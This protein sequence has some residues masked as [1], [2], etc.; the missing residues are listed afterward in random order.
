MTDLYT[1][2][3]AARAADLVEGYR[4]WSFVNALSRLVVDPE[5]FP[6]DREVMNMV[7]MGAV[8]TRTSTGESLRADDAEQRAE[9]ITT[10]FD[11]YARALADLVDARLEATGRALIID[12][13][14]Y[15]R[16]PNPYELRPHDPRPE[17]CL[18]FDDHH[19]P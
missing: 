12:I 2:L 11:P 19:S 5:R 3:I 4:P 17:V 1:D 14:S 9:L 15:P 18:G 7:G 6:D 8:Y 16:D 10:F 13:H